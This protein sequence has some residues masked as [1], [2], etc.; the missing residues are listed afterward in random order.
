FYC[1]GNSKPEQCKKEHQFFICSMK[2]VCHSFM[3]IAIQVHRNHQGHFSVIWNEKGT[4][5]GPEAA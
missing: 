2:A 1:N 4:E 3:C 5:N